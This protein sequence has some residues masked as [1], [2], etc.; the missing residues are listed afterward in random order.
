V[1]AAAS[2]IICGAS[3]WAAFV[4]AI[5]LSFWSNAVLSSSQPIA[6]QRFQKSLLRGFFFVFI[7]GT[8]PELNNSNL[9]TT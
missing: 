6:S 3:F 5:P 7:V 4:L 9:D 1:P 2:Q 8:S